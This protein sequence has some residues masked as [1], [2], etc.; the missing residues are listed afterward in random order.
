MVLM[1]NETQTVLGSRL[2][3][4]DLDIYLENVKCVC[5]CVFSLGLDA[6]LVSGA[7]TE[8]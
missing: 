2:G 3:R 1:N 8:C 6:T 7:R 4:L 5:V